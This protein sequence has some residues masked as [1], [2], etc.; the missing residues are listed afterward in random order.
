[1]EGEII[2]ETHLPKNENNIAESL[3]TAVIDDEFEQ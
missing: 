2:E 1:M 3:L